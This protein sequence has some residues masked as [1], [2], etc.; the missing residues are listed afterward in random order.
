[1]DQIQAQRLRHGSL[2]VPGL[3]PSLFVHHPYPGL[4]PGLLCRRAYGPQTRSTAQIPGKQD[5]RQQPD[6]SPQRFRTGYTS[7]IKALAGSRSTRIIQTS[8]A[9]G[10]ITSRD[11]SKRQIFTNTS[12][13]E[14]PITWQDV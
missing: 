2:D 12:T 3:Q 5:R 8:T 6:N 4:R 13:A 10:P 1:M 7:V 14:G 11:V 9:E